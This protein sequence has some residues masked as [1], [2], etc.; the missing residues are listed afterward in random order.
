MQCCRT[1]VRC[2]WKIPRTVPWVCLAGPLMLC[3]G[4]PVAGFLFCRYD[5]LAGEV[6][7]IHQYVVLKISIFSSHG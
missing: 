2:I 3:C 1:L 7:R 5:K 6:T 4:R